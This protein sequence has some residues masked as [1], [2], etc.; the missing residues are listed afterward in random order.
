MFLSVCK[1]LST[2]H[3]TLLRFKNKSV[4]NIISFLSC[5]VS[6]AAPF[7]SM[8]SVSVWTLLVCL[9]SLIRANSCMFAVVRETMRS[10]DFCYTVCII[11]AG[12]GR[13]QDVSNYQ[14]LVI[15][16]P[17]VLNCRGSCSSLKSGYFP[18][19]HF[20]VNTVQY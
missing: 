8:N 5:P 13:R 12:G 1:R 10:C 2:G 15:K 14:A 18:G 11:P 4:S 7:L 19:S 3:Y 16:P 17:E 9:S 6:F 20:T